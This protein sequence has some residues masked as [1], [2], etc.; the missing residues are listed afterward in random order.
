M[1]SKAAEPQG[2]KKP[3]DKTRPRQTNNDSFV[4][5]FFNVLKKS[6]SFIHNH[7]L[8]FSYCLVKQ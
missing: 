4:S 2:I 1:G 7:L 6:L 3:L 8:E 5:F